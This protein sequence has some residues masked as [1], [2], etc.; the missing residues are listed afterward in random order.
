MR[1]RTGKARDGRGDLGQVRL[2]TKLRNG[3]HGASPCLVHS[4]RYAEQDILGTREAKVDL[5]RGKVHQL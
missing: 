3:E 2:K 4:T 5:V 1:R